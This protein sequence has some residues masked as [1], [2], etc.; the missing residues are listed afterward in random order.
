MHFKPNM[1]FSNPQTSVF[2]ALT[3]P[4]HNMELS[5]DK[6]YNLKKSKLSTYPRFAEMYIANIY[7]GDMVDMGHAST[8][9]SQLDE[10]PTSHQTTSD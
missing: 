1:L 7:A 10:A 3:L 5:Q 8:S 2:C 6:I 9:F 4:Q